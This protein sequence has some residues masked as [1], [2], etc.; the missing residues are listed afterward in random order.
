MSASNEFSLSEVPENERKKILP[1][2]MVL[3]SF[4]FFTGTMFAGGKI[5]MAFNFTD[6]LWIACAGN[7]LLAVYAASLGFIASRSGLNTVMMGR[8]CFGEKGSWLSDFLLGFAELGWYAW[9]TATAAIVLTKLIGLPLWSQTPLMVCL[10][11]LFCVTAIVGFKGLDILSRISVPLMFILLLVSIYL[12]TQKAGGLKALNAISPNESMSYST[13]ITIVFG[14]FA[15]GATQATNWTRFSKSGQSAI[16]ASFLSFMGG[17]GL[18][19]IAG[20]WCA[21][22]YQ[23]SDIVDV[24]V[25]QNLTYAAVIMLF[26]NL[27]TIQGPTIYNVSAA[28]CHLFRIDR[29]RIMTLIAASLG[30]VIA[31]CGMYEW[32]IPFLVLLGSIIPPLGGVIMT[33]YWYRHKSHYPKLSEVQLPQFNIEG[34]AAYGI[35]AT[36]ACFSPWIAPVIG[37]GASAI[38]YILLIEARRLITIKAK[39]P[40][41]FSQIPS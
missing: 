21:L 20:A 3:F 37:I 36:L 31:I 17:N 5:G 23:K 25:L 32:L 34:L 35:G 4:T 10:G 28:A 1:I 26:L 27:W 33:D 40:E 9:G 14:A 6:M 13:A 30:I 7:I 24:M 11:L 19:I 41:S 39:Q 18:M 38:S 12:A 8:F 2:A 22:V 29:R 15:S 16:T